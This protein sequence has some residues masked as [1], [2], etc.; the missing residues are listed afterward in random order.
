MNVLRLGGAGAVAISPLLS[1]L[2]DSTQAP[3]KTLAEAAQQVRFSGELFHSFIN[4]P[5]SPPIEEGGVEDAAA[6]GGAARYDKESIRYEGGLLKDI[7]LNTENQK[8]VT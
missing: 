7:T 3:P 4:R 8:W 1:G 2:A 6:G 5:S